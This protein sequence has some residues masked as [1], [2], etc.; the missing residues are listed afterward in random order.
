MMCTFLFQAKDKNQPKIY[1][2][3]EREKHQ[4]GKKGH[5]DSNYKLQVISSTYDIN[6][7]NCYNVAECV[8]T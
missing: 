2:V 7:G 6:T 3:Y 1:S 4:S 5:T 8:Y